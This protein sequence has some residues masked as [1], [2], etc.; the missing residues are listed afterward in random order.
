V[1]DEDDRPP[2]ASSAAGAGWSDPDRLNTAWAEVRAPDDISEL[3]RDIQTYHRE[4]RA[5]RR[6]A[7]F[8]RVASHPATRKLALTM[9]VLALAAIVASLLTVMRPHSGTKG[10]SARPLSQTSIPVGRQGGLVPSVTL[11]A[12][13]AT[14]VNSRSLRPAVLALLP[15][16]CGCT[17]L[18]THLARDAS[19]HAARLYA[20][21]PLGHDA[22]AASLPGQLPSDT[23]FY[24]ANGDLARDFG[25]Q[26][27]TLVTVDR[28]GTIFKVQPA[29]TSEPGAGL[30]ALLSK[31]LASG[32]SG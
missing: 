8:D 24:D 31:M 14:T 12:T 19:S 5:S 6:R 7:W 11:R 22:E 26:G 25:A 13:D 4:L 27:L 23:V 3:A 29:V 16:H 2:D 9:A 28:D 10:S 32:V 20:I 1:P 30:D 18:L 17:P 15:G 21:A